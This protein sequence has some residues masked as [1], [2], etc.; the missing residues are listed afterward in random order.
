MRDPAPSV[1]VLL[2]AA[3]NGESSAIEQLF[4]SAFPALRRLARS[5][6]RNERTNHTLQPTALV[7]E[8]FLKLILEED[9]SWSG[10]DEFFNLAARRMRQ[11]LVDYARR[12]RSER[13]GGEIPHVSSSDVPIFDPLNEDLDLIVSL[14]QLLD[15]LKALDPRAAEIAELRFYWGLTS[16]EIARRLYM[17][18]KTVERDWAFARAWIYSNLYPERARETDCA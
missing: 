16:E 12:R 6:L 8:A 5:L 18:V 17:T 13:R 9:H 4:R 10:R 7:D 11:I 14:D 15:R 3:D 1:T 2:R